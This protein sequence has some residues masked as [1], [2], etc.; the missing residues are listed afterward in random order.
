MIENLPLM[1]KSIYIYI[2]IKL[3]DIV[4]YLPC[5]IYGNVFISTRVIFLRQIPPHGST[6]VI[7]LGQIT[8]RARILLIKYEILYDILNL[9]L[10]SL[11]FLLLKRICRSICFK[12][13][14]QEEK[15]NSQKNR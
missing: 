2:Y 6:H 10:K 11:S 12:S 3:E 7:L 13:P 15:K 5:G 8:P 1:H 9:L 14:K 4:I